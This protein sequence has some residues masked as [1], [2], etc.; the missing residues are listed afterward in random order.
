[1]SSVTV[2]VPMSALAEYIGGVSPGN[3]IGLGYDQGNYHYL[4]VR[5]IQDGDFGTNRTRIEFDF[6]LNGGS[7]KRVV[8]SVFDIVHCEEYK[9]VAALT[10]AKP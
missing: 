8:L 3:Q 1:M 9:R 7:E 6:R 2:K 4:C 5:P 10:G